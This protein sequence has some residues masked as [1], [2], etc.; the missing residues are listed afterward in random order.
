MQILNVYELNNPIKSIDHHTE[1]NKQKAQKTQ[2]QSICYP[3][4]TPFR[5]KDINRLKTTGWEKTLYK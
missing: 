1:T 3:E 5:F 4:E 2:D